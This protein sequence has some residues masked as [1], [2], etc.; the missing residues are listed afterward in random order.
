MIV[1][2]PLFGNVSI[3]LPGLQG[4]PVQV[5]YLNPSS[6]PRRWRLMVAVPCQLRLGQQHRHGSRGRRRAHHLP[7]RS[8]PRTGFCLGRL[9]PGRRR[10]AVSHEQDSQRTVSQNQVSGNVRG[11]DRPAWWR[12]LADAAERQSHVDMRAGRSCKCPLQLR[13]SLAT[14]AEWMKICGTGD[15]FYWHLTYIRREYIDEA[16]NYIVGSFQALTFDGDAE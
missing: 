6:E 4:Y 16:A 15:C 3:A 1:G 10:D 14:L 7:E 11:C 9:L 8:M 12:Q 5:I 2:D 13:F